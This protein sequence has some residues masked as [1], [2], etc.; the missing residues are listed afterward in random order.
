M[1]DAQ[2]T[3]ARKIL[4]RYDKAMK[5]YLDAIREVQTD[6]ALLLEWFTK[7][8]VPMNEAGGIGYTAEI[9]G[10]NRTLTFDHINALAQR[11]VGPEPN[12]RSI[13]LEYT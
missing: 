9:D 13:L 2:R 4:R 1:D 10:E 3:F 8:A 5:A 7:H 11:H 6:K 12:L